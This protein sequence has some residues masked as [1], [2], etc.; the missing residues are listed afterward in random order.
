MRITAGGSSRR[1]GRSDF[2][3]A[4]ATM[5]P[6]TLFVVLLLP[7]GVEEEQEGEAFYSSVDGIRCAC[8]CGWVGL[9]IGFVLYFVWPLGAVSPSASGSTSA[10]AAAAHLQR[11]CH[12]PQCRHQLQRLPSQCPPDWGWSRCAIAPPPPPSRTCTWHGVCPRRADPL[13]HRA[14]TA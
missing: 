10:A 11:P 9:P 8:V 2:S 5:L 12:R 1:S 6:R 13:A 7:A 3:M 4:S 14:R